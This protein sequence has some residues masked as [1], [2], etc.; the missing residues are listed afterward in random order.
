MENYESFFDTI[1]IPDSICD[2]IKETYIDKLKVINIPNL[3]HQMVYNERNESSWIYQ[4]VNQFVIDNMGSDYSLIER[5]AILKYE[6]GDY[7]KIHTDGKWN[8]QL[9]KELPYHFYGGVEISDKNEFE[10][11]EFIINN[12]KVDFK[13]G[14]LFTHGF[15]T[16]HGVSEVIIG[17]RWSIHFPI[18]KKIHK[19]II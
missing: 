9:N 2:R 3:R 1:I 16:E 12:N 11:G 7:F 17:T 14:R 10:G 6:K 4:Y 13:K 8:T 15:E 19:N 5:V 18:Y